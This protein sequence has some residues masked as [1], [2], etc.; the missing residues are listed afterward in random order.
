[1]K[2]EGNLILTYD[3]TIQ[4]VLTEVQMTMLFLVVRLIK[5]KLQKEG[6]VTKYM[7]LHARVAET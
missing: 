3:Y 4:T 2:H 7:S 1:M 5:S 6:Y